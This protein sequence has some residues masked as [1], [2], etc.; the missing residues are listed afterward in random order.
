[1]GTRSQPSLEV[2][3]SLKPD[4]IIADADRHTGVYP[5]LLKIAPT[6]LLPSRR[7][8]YQS[9][10]DSA[11]LIGKVIGK[12]KAMQYRL[13]Q[14]KQVMQKFSQQLASLHKQ[15]VLFGVAL[16]HGF[17]A[18]S[19]DSYAG[20]VLS[21]LG[22]RTALT[23]RNDKASR[24]INLEQ[25]LAMNPDYLIVGDYTENNI[26]LQWHKHPL[27]NVLKTVRN[28]HVHH[29][30][31]NLWGRCRGILAAEYMARDLVAMAIK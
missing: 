5:E 6:L 15:T 4:L 1:M 27:W 14:H 3:A 28:Q 21:L 29:V 20:G 9:H 23:L 2:I 11:A 17:Y 18:Q 24:Q 26:T 25:L 8:T 12:E 30:D 10:L 13:K 16:E 31:G 22:M 19:A 7:A